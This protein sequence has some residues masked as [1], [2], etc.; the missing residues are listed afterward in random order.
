MAFCL[1][2]F[3]FFGDNYFFNFA[4]RFYIGGSIAYGILTVY[5][6]LKSSCFD[7]IA[8]GRVLL[9]IPLI[10]GFLLFSRVTKFRWAARYPTAILSGIGLGLVFGLTIRTQILTLLTSTIDAL[11]TTDATN[12]VSHPGSAIF[13]LVGVIT[14]LTYFLYSKVIS[15]QFHAPSGR[16]YYLMRLGRIFLMVSVGYLAGATVLLNYA[17]FLNNMVYTLI[18]R[19]VDSIT[20]LLA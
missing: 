1:F 4:E 3:V 20:F 14:V 9:I 19:T 6:T 17:A 12:L 18:K 7:F 16:L 5:K 2:S 8:A 10:I 15:P 13:K 11:M